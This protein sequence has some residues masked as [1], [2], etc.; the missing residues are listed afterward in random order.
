M[1]TATIDFES[2]G[3]TDTEDSDPWVS[4]TRESRDSEPCS[5]DTIGSDTDSSDTAIEERRSDLNPPVVGNVNIYVGAQISYLEGLLLLL[6][7]FLVHAL[8]KRSFE[9]LLRLVGL[10]LPSEAKGTL[11]SSEYMLK[12]AFVKAFPHVPGRKISYLQYLPHSS[13]RAY[14]LW[15]KYVFWGNQRVCLH[16]T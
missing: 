13:R 6:R 8:T 11:P 5:S 10:F 16:I 9:D 3:S 12:R 14:D 15:E 7:F 2:D 1:S 4:E